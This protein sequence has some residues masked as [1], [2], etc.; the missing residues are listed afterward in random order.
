MACKKIKKF[1]KEFSLNRKSMGFFFFGVGIT[2]FILNLTTVINAINLISTLNYSI[3][4]PLEGYYISLVS[5]V[6]L[7]TYSLYNIYI[8][9]T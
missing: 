9:N 1:I 8:D 6:I 7:M 2:M 5:S 4:I 3:R